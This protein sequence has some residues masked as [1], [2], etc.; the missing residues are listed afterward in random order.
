MFV[1]GPLAERIGARSAAVPVLNRDRA[2]VG[3]GSDRKD[4]ATRRWVTD[5][6][7]RSHRGDSSP[8]FAASRTGRA[9]CAASLP[10]PSMPDRARTRAGLASPTIR[11]TSDDARATACAAVGVPPPTCARAARPVVRSR[12]ARPR[13]QD[14]SAAPLPSAQPRRTGR[15]RALPVRPTASLRSVLRTDRPSRS[16]AGRANGIARPHPAGATR[17]AGDRVPADRA[18]YRAAAPRHPARGPVRRP[19]AGTAPDPGASTRPSADAPT[20]QRQHA[21]PR[22]ERT[23]AADRRLIDRCSPLNSRH[24]EARARTV[25]R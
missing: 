11:A 10:T 6:G 2:P 17:G 21:L 9:R 25:P 14:P 16:L 8:R 3:R 22:P 4:A 20:P 12:H 1:S 23:P 15:A 18:A 24:L 7:V 5:A 13:Y 19:A